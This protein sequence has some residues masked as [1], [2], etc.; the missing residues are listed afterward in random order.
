MEENYEV[1]SICIEKVNLC[2]EI[3]DLEDI[4]VEY[5][6]KDRKVD[7][8]YDMIENIKV[9]D[10][11]S[12]AKIRT[13][14]DYYGNKYE[15]Y[16]QG[17]LWPENDNTDYIEY[18]LLKNDEMQKNKAITVYYGDYTEPSMGY[19][20]SDS[21]YEISEIIIDLYEKTMKEIIVFQIRL[22]N[23]AE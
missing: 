9:E 12:I 21:I 4:I 15:I 13:V 22:L 23:L 7:D 16:F 5:I 11:F 20:D 19:I 6:L 8:L 18:V 14:F 17:E 3:K 10:Y 1:I 2:K